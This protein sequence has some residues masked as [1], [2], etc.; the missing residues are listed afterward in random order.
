MA[1]VSGHV[2][3]VPR[4]RG[5]QFYLKYRTPSGKQLERKLGPAWTERSRPP[6]GYFT[7]K[8]A[9]AELAAL[10]TDLRRGEVPDPGDRSGKTFADAREEW[11]RYCEADRGLEGTT[12]RDYRNVSRGVL[13]EEFGADTPLDAI[14]EGRIESF[15]A[16]MLTGEVVARRGGYTVV[17]RDDGRAISRRTA[18]KRLVLLGGIFKRAR[19]LKWIAVDPTADVEPIT[20]KPSGDFNVLTVEQVELVV[21]CC[22]D[23]L[24]AAAVLVAAYTGLRTG[25]LRALRWRDI[26]FAAATIHVRSNMPA[27]G[28]EKAPKSDK[29]RSVPMM[30]DAA[31]VLDR[32][33]RREHF[34]APTDRV[35]ASET[36]GMVGEDACRDALYEALE[37]AGIDRKS[38]PARGGFVFHDLRHTFGTLAVRVWPLS[39]VQAYMGHADIQTT[40][41]YVHHIPKTGAAREF[42]EAV[43]R[44]RA[45]G[46]AIPGVAEPEQWREAA[47][48]DPAAEMSPETSP[49]LP[50]TGRH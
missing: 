31:R 11:L 49:E 2:K 34:T 12:L 36:G 47:D 30:E 14:N 27:G 48:P 15:R 39:D 26:D 5:D 4:K 9:E 50:K 21:R 10:L 35:F 28:E 32:L 19:R 13:T 16:K 38:F 24:F 8:M 40:M 29:V 45:A 20:L 1:V 41:R 25:E 17:E 6:A 43:E 7:R 42:T 37:A 44:M 46:E 18:Q 22:D 3:L 33:S 23:E